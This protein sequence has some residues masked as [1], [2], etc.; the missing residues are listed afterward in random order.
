VVT[1]FGPDT[2]ELALLSADGE[3][4]RDVVALNGDLASSARW[5]PEGDRISF[6]RTTPCNY[7]DSGDLWIVGP[8]GSDQQKVFEDAHDAAWSPDGQFFVV[9]RSDLL[10]V[11]RDGHIVRRL[12]ATRGA[13]SEGLSWQ[14]G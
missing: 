6:I 14:R 2:G 1:R 10:I 5:S 11:G 3:F 7:C 4:Q 8:D 13:G 9:L 12:R